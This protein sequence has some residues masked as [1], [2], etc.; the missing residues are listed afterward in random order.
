MEGVPGPTLLQRLL[1]RPWTLFVAGQRMVE[2]HTWLHRLPAEGFPAPPEPLVERSLDQIQGVI[3]QCGFD[4]L[5]PGVEWLSAN[6]LWIYLWHIFAFYLWKFFLP[7]V[8]GYLPLVAA[9][10]VFLLG[11]SAAATY[12][13]HHVG[14]ALKRMGPE[15]WSQM[16]PVPVKSMDKQ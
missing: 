6:S 7:P 1:D 14:E 8:G 15:K 2:L 16:K 11:F 13:Q 12:A 5:T 3:R 10:M 9:K 4:G